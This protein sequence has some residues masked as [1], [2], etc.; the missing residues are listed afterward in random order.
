MDFRG[1][2]DV[3]NGVTTCQLQTF[4]VWYREIFFSAAVA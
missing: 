2:K 1:E 3:D 4:I